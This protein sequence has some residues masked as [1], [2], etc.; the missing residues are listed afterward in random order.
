MVPTTSAEFSESGGQ[1]VPYDLDF[2]AATCPT[3]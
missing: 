2:G 1:P 3:T